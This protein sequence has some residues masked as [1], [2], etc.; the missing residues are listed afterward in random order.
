MYA[1]KRWFGKCAPHPRF[2][3]IIKCLLVLVC[4]MLENSNVTS[5]PK[6]TERKKFEENIESKEKHL[7]S[8]F[9]LLKSSL[10]TKRTTTNEAKWN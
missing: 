8:I 7:F 6:K 9:N 2:A 4:A 3:Y 5:K 10:E 1:Q